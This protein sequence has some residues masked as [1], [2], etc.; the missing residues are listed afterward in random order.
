M[1]QILQESTLAAIIDEQRQITERCNLQYLK[2]LKDRA[3]K[4]QQ[5]Y[6]D[7]R[8]KIMR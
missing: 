2:V 5:E 4:A 8:N 6:I 1:T 7:A 3:C